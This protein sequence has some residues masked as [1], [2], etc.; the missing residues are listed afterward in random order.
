MITISKTPA[1]RL[2][3]QKIWLIGLFSIMWVIENRVNPVAVHFTVMR[4]MNW[5]TIKKILNLPKDSVP[6][7]LVIK[8]R[9]PR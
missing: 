7:C 5:A 8:A 1:I 9:M 6:S 2:R 4:K 3:A